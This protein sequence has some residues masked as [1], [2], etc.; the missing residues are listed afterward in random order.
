MMI[1]PEL[2]QDTNALYLACIKV[3]QEATAYL[4]R[5]QVTV[6]VLND[7]GR[8]IL[9]DVLLHPPQQEG[10]HLSVEGLHGQHT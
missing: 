3:G 4:Q 10:Q 8:E 5:A 9:Q 1:Y 2:N 6:V 7:F